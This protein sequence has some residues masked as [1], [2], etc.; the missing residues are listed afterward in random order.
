[1]TP[2]FGRLDAVSP[3]AGAHNAA[4]SVGTVSDEIVPSDW[5]PEAMGEAVASTLNQHEDYAKPGLQMGRNDD[6]LP[7]DAMQSVC[8]PNLG[9][10]NDHA[11]MTP[12]F[13]AGDKTLP[14]TLSSPG[15]QVNAQAYAAWLVNMLESDAT[16]RQVKRDAIAGRSRLQLHS[17]GGKIVGCGGGGGEDKVRGEE[18]MI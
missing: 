2:D 17:P 14:T 3:D 1:V 5:L 15:S 9:E 12:P 13:T 16:N 18:E 4:G 10:E 7:V 8:L 11:S 6:Y